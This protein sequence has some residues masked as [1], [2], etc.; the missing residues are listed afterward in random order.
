MP[1]FRVHRKLSPKWVDVLFIG[2]VVGG[3]PISFLIGLVQ[4]GLLI[5]TP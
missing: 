1:Q 4:F 5:G 2:L 3:A